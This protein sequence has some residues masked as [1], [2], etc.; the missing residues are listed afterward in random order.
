M[1]EQVSSQ[2][3]GCNESK[4]VFDSKI[5]E[6]SIPHQRE[7]SKSEVVSTMLNRTGE[8]PDNYVIIKIHW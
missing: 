4:E 5:S 1:C 2:K 8:N 3:G 6:F 7:T